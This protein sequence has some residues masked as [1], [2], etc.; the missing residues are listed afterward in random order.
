MRFAQGFSFCGSTLTV[1]GEP[2]TGLVRKARRDFQPEFST[3]RFSRKLG[4]KTASSQRQENFK[5]FS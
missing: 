3:I 4:D 5:I 2:G 1:L